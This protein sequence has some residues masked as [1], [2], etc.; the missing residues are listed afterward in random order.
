MLIANTAGHARARHLFSPGFSERALKV[1]EP[2]IRRYSNLLASKL[3]ELAL[4]G[5]PVD[6][7][8]M[9]NLTTFDIMAEFTF[10]ESLGL[11][12]SGKYSEWLSNLIGAIGS[13]PLIHIIKY[14]PWTS[15][16]FDLLQPEWMRKS[17]MS[18]FK[19]SADRVDKRMERGASMYSQPYMQLTKA[20]RCY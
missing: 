9:A 19:H 4:D 13:L 11:L 3:R 5:R 1:Q 6:M 2:L 15:K 20:H 12:E 8:V 17:T 18:Y 7:T 10:G 14:Y 16:A